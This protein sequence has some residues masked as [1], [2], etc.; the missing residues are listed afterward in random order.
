V[1]PTRRQLEAYV[2]RYWSDEL[3]VEYEIGMGEE[4]LVYWNRKLGTR[5]L[6]PTF[7]DGFRI[8][9]GTFATFTRGASGQPEGFTIS[10]GRVWRVGF[11]RMR[12]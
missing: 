10:A 4:G 1:E 7:R 5:E 9:G 11:R 2:G 6:T 8:G 3:A 12:E